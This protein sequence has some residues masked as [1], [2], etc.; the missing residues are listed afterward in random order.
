MIRRHVDLQT[1]RSRISDGSISSARELFRDLLLL[2]NNALVFFPKDSPEH[3]SAIV[4]REL[5]AERLSLEPCSPSRSCNSV[6]SEQCG[7]TNPVVSQLC[8]HK[9]TALEKKLEEAPE[10]AF[11]GGITDQTPLP[12]RRGV[13]RPA[14]GTKRRF[15]SP[16]AYPARAR[17]KIER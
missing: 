1:V 14:M 16:K 11:R 8:E 17:R 2:S 9:P 12:K 7:T 3:K 4:L 10:K 6:I 5:V 15:K 13:G